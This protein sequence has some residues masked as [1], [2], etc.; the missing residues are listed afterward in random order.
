MK[1]KGLAIAALAAVLTL[2]TGAVSAWAA[3]GWVQSGSSWT[4]YDSNGYQV[5][6]EWKKGNDD[7]WRYLDSDGKMAVNTWVDG[8]QYYVD[9]N[10]IMVTDKW[11]QVKNEYR[12]DDEPEYVWYYFNSSGKV[13]M[14][15]WKKIS[16]SWYYFDS[17]GVMQTG[18]V[19]DNMYYCGDNGVMKTGWQKLYPPDADEYDTDRVTPA[20]DYEDSDGKYWYYF[21]SNGKKYMP[22]SDDGDYY[23]KKI[24]GVYYCFDSEGAMQT[25][26]VNVG[27]RDDDD[28]PISD[29]RY[30]G[31]DGKVKTGWLSLEPPSTIASRYENDV[32]WFYFTS[33]GTPRTGPE[34]PSVSDLVKINGL[35]FL[36]N[37]DGNPVYGLRK[38]YLSEN[39]QEY[40]AYY[41]GDRATSSVQKGKKKVEE[42]DG[43]VS[44]YYFSDT[45]R[46]FTG[47]K[48][49]CL[50][51]KGKLQSAQDGEKYAVIS[52]PNGNSY[53]N[54]VVNKYGKVAKSTT[55]KNSDGV[56]YKTG[57][58]GQLVQVDG[59]NV[60]N[61]TFEEPL[62]PV[63]TERQ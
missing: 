28:A 23:Q 15:T 35:T 31:S 22:D 59:E 7:K 47:V 4:Y 48:D 54:Y 42:G 52:I 56:K 40:T 10:G 37:E 29:F 1:K 61:E 45:G 27:T 63:W 21:A 32:E 38:L 41:F 8:D 9:S 36:F 25:G 19:D 2:G 44:E 5:Y 6:N 58:G 16:D 50:Y 43:N 12:Y 20:S 39:S 13:V 14:D 3:S 53:T 49:G 11:L 46:G 34:N 62:E 26:W 55:V 57:S 33:N 60:G 30:Y 51:Y 17:N 24:N 18:W